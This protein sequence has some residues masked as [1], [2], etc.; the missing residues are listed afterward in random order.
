MVKASNKETFYKINVKKKRIINFAPIN[1]G[2]RSKDS[3]HQKNHLKI[4]SYTHL[5]NPL[6]AF[7]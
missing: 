2:S 3:P 6:L 1:V 5:F 7:N 4:Y